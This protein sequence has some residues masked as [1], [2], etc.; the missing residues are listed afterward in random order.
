MPVT[1]ARESSNHYKLKFDYSD[2]S[3]YLLF[4]STNAHLIM[5]YNGGF[6]V[7]PTV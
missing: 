7:W 2:N 6:P 5:A 1:R 3:C 4:L